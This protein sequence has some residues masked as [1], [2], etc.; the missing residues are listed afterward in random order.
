MAFTAGSPELAK[1]NKLGAQLANL[2]G[3]FGATGA[4]G[5]TAAKVIERYA[6]KLGFGIT[7]IT[8]GSGFPPFGSFYPSLGLDV[9]AALQNPR[10]E[11]MANGITLGAIAGQTV[12]IYLPKFV[13]SGEDYKATMFSG[14]TLQAATTTGGSTFS[15]FGT[16]RAF[17]NDRIV[18]GDGVFFVT[19]GVTSAGAGEKAEITV[20]GTIGRVY[21]VGTAFNIETIGVTRGTSG[22]AG[23]TFE[24][25]SAGT[26]VNGGFTAVIGFSTGY[27]VG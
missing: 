24:R 17:A 9:A 3:T 25:F 11:T 21:P 19:G 15:A 22:V 16:F 10:G 13:R 2:F 23:S 1:A 7:G 14:V 12:G 4:A 26:Q 6:K 20:S 27:V 18:F 8:T 5:A